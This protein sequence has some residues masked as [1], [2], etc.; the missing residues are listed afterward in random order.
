MPTDKRAGI[1]VRPKR[2]G[3]GGSSLLKTVVGRGV[4][5]SPEPLGVGEGRRG[6]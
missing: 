4:A 1:S 5:S 3:E 6:S 2:K